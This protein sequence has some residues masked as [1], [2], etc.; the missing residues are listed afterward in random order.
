MRIGELLPSYGISY[1][2]DMAKLNERASTKSDWDTRA[3]REA[4]AWV[5]AHKAKILAEWLE[6]GKRPT[7]GCVI[8][9]I[10]SLAI[11]G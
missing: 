2:V 6:S 10:K 11:E 3:E 1:D 9:Q 4:K 7:C 5:A 8:P